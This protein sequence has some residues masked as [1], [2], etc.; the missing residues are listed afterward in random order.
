MQNTHQNTEPKPRSHKVPLNWKTSDI[1]S[2]HGYSAIITG[3]GGIG[4]E[5]ALALAHAGC[6]VII[7]G[8]NPQKGADAIARI[9]SEVPSANVRFEQVDLASLQ[10][11]KYFGHR[12]QSQRDSLDI[13]INNAA[14]MN[15]PKRQVTTDGLEMQ[16]GTNYLGHFALTAQLLPL[17]N[18][19]SHAR[20]VTLSSVAARQGVI[21]FADLQAEQNYDPMKAYSQSKLACLMFAL[22]LQQLSEAGQ[23]GIT[24]I[25]AHPG[26]SRTDLLHNAPGKRSMTGIVRSLLWFMFQPA[27]QGALPSLF[28][29]T[30]AEARGGYYYGPAKFSET[31]GAPA[32]AVI[33]P[34]AL[35]EDAAAQLWKASEHL[36]NVTF[37][38]PNLSAENRIP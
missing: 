33:P 22:E 16:F 28:A 4:L 1:P 36:A 8:R 11:V 6:E 27:S 12:L 9:C 38:I 26:I 23:W 14:V 15:P 31:R 25:A 30:S 35:D 7:A 34:Q 13:L 20:V 21:N 18:K 19:S 24:S 3:T 2:L 29:A 17:L 5:N 32:V 10:S 37:T